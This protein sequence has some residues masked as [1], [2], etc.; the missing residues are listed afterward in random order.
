MHRI[1]IA[2]FAYFPLTSATSEAPVLIQKAAESVDALKKSGRLEPG[3][4]DILDK[5]IETLEDDTLPDL[6][7][8][9][10]PGT[11]SVMMAL[12]SCSRHMVGYF[13]TITAP[14]TGKNYVTILMVLNHPLSHGTIVSMSFTFISSVCT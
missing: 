2:S 8:I 7:I 12:H 11:S 4:A 13:T 10:F 3:Q 6:E 14:E 9:A 1:G 5:Q